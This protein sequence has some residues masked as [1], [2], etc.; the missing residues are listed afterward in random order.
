MTDL[1]PTHEDLYRSLLERDDRSNEQWF[2]A[3]RS[4]RI[5]CRLSCP[6]RKPK[7]ENCRFFSSTHEC[8]SHGYRPCKR[9]HPMDELSPTVR[10]LL[11]ALDE[12]PDARWTE[13]DL[14][15]RGLEPSTVRRTFKR[16]LGMTF[17]ALARLRRLQRGS[18]ALGAGERVIDAQLEAG[19][20]SAS[21][22][23]AAIGRWLGTA[24]STLGHSHALAVHWIDGPLGAMVAVADD[25]ALHLLEFAD[26]RALGAELRRLRDR[27]GP[28]GI[29]RTEVFEQL[30]GELGRYFRGESS[31]FQTP[32]AMYGTAVQRAVWE[33]LLQIPAGETRS[34]RAIAEAIGRPKAF[35]AVARANGANQLA[36]VVPCHRVVGSDGSMT[37]YGGGIWRKRRLIAIEQQLAGS[38]R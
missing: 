26:R 14:V 15:A 2:V 34:Y 18:T 28:I 3:V 36:I 22:F 20:E 19:F 13:E 35:R 5:F 30:E 12:A 38:A 27:C 10:S 8:L 21:G 4:T 24:P 25:R 9:C 7:A 23:R 17:L 31:Q 29:G 32:L 11:D 1:A 33:Q 6:A 16:E 37:G